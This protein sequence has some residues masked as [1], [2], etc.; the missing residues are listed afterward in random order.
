MPTSERVA[1][2]PLREPN[3]AD[4]VSN[5]VTRIQG[6]LVGLLAAVG[7]AE[8]GGDAEAGGTTGVSAPTEGSDAGS[9]AASSGPQE[10][11][12]STTAPSSSTGSESGNESG[13]SDATT[14]GPPPTDPFECDALGD[15]VVFC[16][17]FEEGDLSIWDDYDGNPAE[18][19]A[20]VEDEGPFALAGNHVG[21]LRVPA[22]RGGADFVK[23]LPTT[24]DRLYARWYILYEEGFDFDAPNHGGGLHAG[25]RD[26][27]GR[28]DFQPQG[29][30]WFSSWVEYQTSD[31]RFIAYTYYRGMYMDC[32]D[33]AGAC[34]GDHFPCM[35][36]EGENYCEQPQ[37]RETVVPP[38]IEAGQWYCVEMMMDA[39]TPSTDGSVADGQLDVWVD[40]VEI[41]PWTDLWL[42][43]SA[44]LQLSML[45]LSLFH[46]EEHSVE[47]VM[48]DHVV[49]ST[50]RV[51]CP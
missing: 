2:R 10:G 39:G 50:E 44:E 27:L 16:S 32:A 11:S 26:F 31:P 46:H 21:R 8:P 4:T 38:A 36:D 15:A 29:D 37:H 33:P 35:I 19:N 48:Y 51:G 41:G 13:S 9:D 45:W 22:G 43:T 47:G 17:D 5:V 14:S 24:H 40:G 1:L 49:V 23:V 25:S 42:R 30:D 7:C 34:W 3:R 6:A 20:L 18:T 12:G 28:S